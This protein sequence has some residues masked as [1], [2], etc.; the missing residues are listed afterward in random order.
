MKD[1]PNP[2]KGQFSKRNYRPGGYADYKPGL[3][4]LSVFEV[5]KSKIIE[6]RTGA[7]REAPVVPNPIIERLTQESAVMACAGTGVYAELLKNDVDKARKKARAR[8][9]V[10]DVPGISRQRRGKS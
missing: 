1:K 9:S 6:L 10:Q 3:I 8:F 7:S 5:A 2:P 4:Y